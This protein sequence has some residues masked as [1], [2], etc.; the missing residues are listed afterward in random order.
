MPM[1]SRF[2][3]AL[4]GVHL[5]PIAFAQTHWTAPRTPDGH[6]DLQGVWTNSTMTPLERPADLAGKEFFSEQEAASS[7][8]ELGRRSTANGA[9]AARK[10]TSPGPITS[11]GVTAPI[12]SSA[13]CERHSCM[14]RRTEKFPR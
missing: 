14:S 1:K 9:M 11:L 10:P 5:R 4:I 2:L 7:R 13:L 8:P 6:P 12:R 3:S